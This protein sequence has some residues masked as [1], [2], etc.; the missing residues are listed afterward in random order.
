MIAT[1]TLLPER[2]SGRRR[3]MGGLAQPLMKYAARRNFYTFEASSRKWFAATVSVAPWQIHLRCHAVFQTINGAVLPRSYRS[4]KR[5][6]RS[7]F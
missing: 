7:E 3:I 2:R 1:A 4:A 5:R 6:A